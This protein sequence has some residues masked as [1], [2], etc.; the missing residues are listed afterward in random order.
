MFFQSIYNVNRLMLHPFDKNIDLS[1]ID[2]VNYIKKE[3]YVNTSKLL[4]NTGSDIIEFMIGMIDKEICF[5]K[6]AIG[7]PSTNQQ[8]HTDRP[9]LNCRDL[10]QKTA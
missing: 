6:L 1:T 5:S 3:K 8:I 9:P 10:L 7:T 2:M 4:H